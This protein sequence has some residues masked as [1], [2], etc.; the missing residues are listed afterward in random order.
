MSIAARARRWLA[1]PE[2]A[3]HLTAIVVALA[4]GILAFQYRP[5]SLA[6][7]F[8]VF[9]AG[10][11]VPG[12]YDEQWS[13]EYERRLSAAL[14]ALFAS[15]SLV[16]VY[17]VVMAVLQQVFDQTAAEVG[18]FVTSWLLGLAGARVLSGFEVES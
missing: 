17:L 10:I 5:H 6:G 12:I 7:Y 18:A 1:S 9:L 3:A 14:W 8:L 2:F 16:A 11:A 13:V 4:A 15:L